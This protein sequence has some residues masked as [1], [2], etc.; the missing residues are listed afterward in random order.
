[1]VVP[2]A[3]GLRRKGGKRGPLNTNEKLDVAHQVLV[4]RVS[5]TEVAQGLGVSCGVISQTMSK[6]RKRPELLSEL[7]SRKYASEM[8][9]L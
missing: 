4:E 6:V 7:L 8:K 1:M 9:E 3:H 5:H 2:A